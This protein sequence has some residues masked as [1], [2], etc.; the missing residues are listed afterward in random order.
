M[1]R[2]RIFSVAICALMAGMNLGC[3]TRV[4]PP[5][6]VVDPVAVYIVDYGRH[7]SLLLPVDE[8]QP[9]SLDRTTMR[10]Y[11]FG[12]WVYYANS[13]NSVRHGA[14]ALLWKTDGTL[15]RRD[16]AGLGPA[17]DE[18][19]IEM[20]ARIERT[21]RVERVHAVVVERAAAADLLAS[22]D[23]RFD[24]G[25]ANRPPITNDRFGLDFVKD[26]S[27]YSVLRHC[28][29]SM[30]DWLTE[31]GADSYGAPLISEFK[32]LRSEAGAE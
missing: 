17:P 11:T 6:D 20:E 15:G 21:L 5:A 10:E 19:P 25:A 12:D 26:D 4:A 8:P 30:R 7:A 27:S 29:H 13:D 3:A 1:I 14:R 18:A 32:V 24:A 28:N 9:G 22:L 31:M 16:L 23:A 2:K